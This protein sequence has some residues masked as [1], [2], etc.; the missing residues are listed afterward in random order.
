MKPM[1]D[2]PMELQIFGTNLSDWENVEQSLRLLGS[3]FHRRTGVLHGVGLPMGSFKNYWDVRFHGNFS[4]NLRFKQLAFRV[5]NLDTT[6]IFR[7]VSR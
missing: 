4:W 5:P 1:Q 6:H 2:E 3:N 7:N